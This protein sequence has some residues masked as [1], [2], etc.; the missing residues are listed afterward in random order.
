ML[1]MK[2]VPVL[3]G[4]LMAA[5]AISHVQA[6]PAETMA[7]SI[8]LAA[9]VGGVP[10][11]CGATFEGIGT[12]KSSVRMTDFRLYVSNVR[13]T[14]ADG[15]AVPVTLA[16]DGM[17][18][19]DNVAL[20]DFEDATGS[21]ASGTPQTRSVIEG[22]IPAGT[23]TGLTF[24]LGLPF[25]KNHRDPAVQPS[26][27]NLTRLFWSWNAGYKF[28]RLDMRTTGM[29]NG[30]VI[31][32]G[33]TACNGATATTAPGECTF[34]NRA[35]ITIPHFNVLTD[36]VV[37]DVAALLSGSDVNS[38]QERTAVGCMSAQNDAECG[39][40]FERLGLPFGDRPATAQQVFTV[41]R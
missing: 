32:L 26:P 23:Y 34:P 8:R 36:T 14:R 35:P 19:L 6:G 22:E 33:S 39:P 38:N 21:C 20:I 7:V 18:Q 41:R 28:M 25:D 4:L 24:D 31:H 16:Q 40:L 2:T 3:A 10:F 13:L 5:A 9:E 29:P 30:W 27:L 1:P 11:S 17:W 15:T 37:M 12:T